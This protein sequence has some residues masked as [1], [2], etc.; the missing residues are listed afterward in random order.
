LFWPKIVPRVG[1]TDL[2]YTWQQ[3]LDKK[4]E[5][6]DFFF[7][8][9]ISHMASGELFQEFLQHPEITVIKR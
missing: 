9:N 5:V 4:A 3:S 8:A 1:N 6:S 2:L 7:T